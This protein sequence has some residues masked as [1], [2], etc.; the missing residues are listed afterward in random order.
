MLLSLTCRV[1]L[2]REE[3]RLQQLLTL[4][5]CFAVFPGRGAIEHMTGAHTLILFLQ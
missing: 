3:G 4:L 5:R 1:S 2:R